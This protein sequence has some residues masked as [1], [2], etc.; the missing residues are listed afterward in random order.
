MLID[1]WLTRRWNADLGDWRV[2]WNFSVGRNKW[3]QSFPSSAKDRVSISRSWFIRHKSCVDVGATL[4]CS[5][6]RVSISEKYWIVHWDRIW[7]NRLLK[8]SSRISL[9]RKI[10]N[11]IYLDLSVLFFELLLTFS[12]GDI[13]KANWFMVKTVNIHQSKIDVVKFDGTK[14][15]GMWRCKEMDA[16]NALNLKDTLLL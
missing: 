15:F 3:Y 6:D 5:W 1:S 12:G 2:I 7:W 13:A 11:F 8:N 10:L 9:W 14:N 16:L 4:D